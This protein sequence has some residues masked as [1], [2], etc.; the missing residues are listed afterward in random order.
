M[1]KRIILTIVVL[2]LTVGLVS[3]AAVAANGKPKPSPRAQ[4]APGAPFG[5]CKQHQRGTQAWRDCV[6]QAAQARAQRSGVRG[7]GR[8]HGVGRVCAQHKGD[9]TAFRNCVRTEIQRRM[10]AFRA[11]KAAHDRGTEAFRNCIRAAKRP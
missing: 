3:S 6:R 2:G 11:C 8:A 7:S 9:R 5:A 10:A 1:T 4:N